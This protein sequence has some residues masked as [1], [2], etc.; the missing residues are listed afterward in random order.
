MI[1][2]LHICMYLICGETACAND[3]YV[4]YLE[5]EMG[6]VIYMYMYLLY[7]VNLLHGILHLMF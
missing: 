4:T 5:K 2:G 7:E 1:L 3:V 6:H